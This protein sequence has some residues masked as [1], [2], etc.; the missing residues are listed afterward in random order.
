MV[1]W[2]A[3]FFKLKK[4]ADRLMKNVTGEQ[5]T[6]QSQSRCL[7]SVSLGGFAMT[8]KDR[9]AFC[10]RVGLIVASFA[11]ISGVVAEPLLR[12]V[13]PSRLIVAQR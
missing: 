11:V 13:W 7:R 6:C 3:A 10:G 5:A 8:R 1:E 9:V 12:D 4:W 2:K